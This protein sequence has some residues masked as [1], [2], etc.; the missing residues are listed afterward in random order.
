MSKGRRPSYAREVKDHGGVR[1][2]LQP[3]FLNHTAVAAGRG[4][5]RPPRVE[6]TQ[7]LLNQ[8]PAALGG[9]RVPASADAAPGVRPGARGPREVL[10]QAAGPIPGRRAVSS[11]G[12][13]QRHSP[14]WAQAPQGGGRRH[15]RD[16]LP[17]IQEPGKPRNGDPSVFTP[18]PP[19]HQHGASPS[20]RKRGVSDG[21][22]ARKSAAS[23]PNSNRSV[24]SVC[25]FVEP[26]SQFRPY[27]EDRLV[28]IDPFMSG[29]FGTEQ[30]GF[31]AVY[32]GHGGSQ[33][34]DY[35]QAQLH[36]VLTAELRV[37]L[38]DHRRPSSPLTD[39]AIASAL[40][41]TFQK[42]DHG[43]RSINA[44][45]FGCTATVAL[46]RRMTHGVRIHVANVGDS[47][48]IVC[49]S[50]RGE[51]RLSVD[52]RPTDPSE[53][54]RVREEGGFVS[55][56]RVGGEL[57][58]SRA[59]GDLHLKT[60]GVSCRPDVRAHDATRDVALVIASDGLWDT[61]Q[62]NDVSRIIAE[63][64]RS[65][66]DQIAQKLVQEAQRRGSMDNIACLVAFL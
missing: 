49:D 7:H 44:W 25:Q 37:A 10:H 23:A 40:S 38:Q 41:K 27:M 53:A 63:Q 33:A 43:L 19:E 17:G 3:G 47:R 34:A 51:S 64:G 24:S 30:W 9:Y 58:V 26:N 36:N 61:L 66:N 13:A 45:Q 39:E 42:V 65:R 32:D 35:C 6:S 48:A 2:C 55:M 28:S 60:S 16:Q 62:D 8:L 29:A 20:D 57:A 14:P 12:G 4:L 18:F 5:G 56:G 11:E 50:S 54:R 22:K 46:V 15:G 59:L 31:F 21:P 52:H 1:D